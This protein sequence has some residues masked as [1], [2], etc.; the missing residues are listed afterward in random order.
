MKKNSTNTHKI[1]PYKKICKYYSLETNNKG[2]V[3]LSE[4]IADSDE[5][6]KIYHK[7]FYD[8]N[9]EIVF[10]ESYIKK[11]LL[12][13]EYIL[14]EG[15]I[16]KKRLFDEKGNEDFYLEYI[17][18]N[19]RLCEKKALDNTNKLIYLSYYDKAGRLIKLLVFKR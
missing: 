7:V 13:C 6:D 11:D 8:E 18:K 1:I 17:Y 16:T 12:N 2:K 14:N 19:N 15:R 4:L 9:N 10:I 5:P 3:N